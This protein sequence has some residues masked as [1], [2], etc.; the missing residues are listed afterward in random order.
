MSGGHDCTTF[1]NYI[2]EPNEV[3]IFRRIIYRSGGQ[4]HLSRRKEIREY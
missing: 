2:S 4:V 1:I 3:F